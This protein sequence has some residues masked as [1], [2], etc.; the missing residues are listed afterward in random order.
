MAQ[1]KHMLIIR[2]SAMGDVAMTVPVVYAFAKANPEI[3]ISFLSKP[4][5][6]PIVE[7]IPNVTFIPA[8]VNTIHKGVSGMW[9]LSR[10]LKKLGITHVADLHNVIRS[11]MLRKFLNLPSVCLD[12]GRPDKKALTRSTDKVFKALKTTIA[13]YQDV[14]EELGGRHFITEPL[15]KPNKHEEVI[16]FTVGCHKKWIGIAPFAAHQGKQYPLEL[17]EQV[18]RELD[19]KEQY[20]LFLFG[21]PEEEEILR[22]LSQGC[23]MTKV[24]AGK[25]KF[26]E[27]INLIS[28]LD[29]ML[30][31]DS[32]NAHLAAMYGI[33][34]IT[35]WGVTHPHAGFAPF[36]QEAN[37][38]LSD[39][40]K[41]PQIP[42]SI[43]GN[44]VPE[45]YENVMTTILP[46]D[47]VDKITD[48]I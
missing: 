15:P 21:A 41:Y 36:N 17:M 16:A 45:G 38:L 25:L 30:A 47:I 8:E 23:I 22:D 28:Q 18:I 24:V 14:I 26:K 13:R 43:Y 48:T 35:L 3:K 5:F 27:E 42:T 29:G 31:M 44:V 39:R 12:K 32:G 2:L 4:F 6:R 34:T 1:Q 37:C 19:G 20:N 10:Q 40:K 7:A 46:V 33:P 11:K 9:K